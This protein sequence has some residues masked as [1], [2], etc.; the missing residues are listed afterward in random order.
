[1]FYIFCALIYKNICLALF[2]RNR[3]DFE[4]RL[5]LFGVFLEPI[6]N[7]PPILLHDNTRPFVSQ[8]TVQQNSTSGLLIRP[9]S[10]LS[11][12]LIYLPPSSLPPTITFS[13]TLMTSC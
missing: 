13:S 1:M 3:L 6:N 10:N 5:C 7:R 2:C 12:P 4:L 11:S 8:I 9:P